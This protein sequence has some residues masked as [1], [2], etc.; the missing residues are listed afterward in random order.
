MNGQTAKLFFIFWSGDHLSTP[1]PPPSLW[2][3]TGSS[4]QG[5]CTGS[6]RWRGIHHVCMH[7]EISILR[8][9]LLHLIWPQHTQPQGIHN[10]HP[11]ASLTRG[12]EQIKTMWPQRTNVHTSLTFLLVSSANIK[13]HEQHLHHLCSG[14]HERFVSVEEIPRPASDRQ[15]SVT[16]CGWSRVHEGRPASPWRFK[17]TYLFFS[18]SSC[19]MYKTAGP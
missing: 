6:E 9:T 18:L 17:W 1:P 7:G 19:P 15:S 13:K 2:I 14:T 5:N 3:C 12:T 11:G 8:L 10:T 4:G 16:L